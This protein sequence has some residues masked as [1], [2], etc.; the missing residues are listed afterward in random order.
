VIPIGRNGPI[1]SSRVLGLYRLY[2][3]PERLARAVLALVTEKS[4]NTLRQQIKPKSA[5]PPLAR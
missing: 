3:Q 4:V 1:P 5:T 2:K